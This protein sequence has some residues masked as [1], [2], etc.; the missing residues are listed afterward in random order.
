[1]SAVNTMTTPKLQMVDLQ[2][3]YQHIKHEIL[4]GFENVLNNSAYI[5]GQ[6]VNDLSENLSNYLNCKHVIPCGNGTD[7]LLAALMALDLQ[8]GD[9]IITVPFT[10]V[11]TVEV[12]SLLGL[13]PVFVDIHPETYN[14]DET[15]LEK[16]IS[17]K[18][19]VIIP[20]HLYGQCCNMEAICN[21]AKEN[22]LFVVEDNAQSIGADYTFSDG[23]KKKS[24]TI[25]DIGCTSFYPSKN[26]GA[27][28][29]AGAIFTNN[30]EIAVKL[31][32]IANHGQR[33]KYLSEFVGLNSRLDS[34]Q[35]VVLNTKL[36]YLDNYIE[37]RRK[38]ADFYDNAFKNIEN[39]VIPKRVNYSNHVFHQYTLHVGNQRDKIKEKLASAG[40]PSM[41]YYPY[42]LH[43]HPAYAYLN[44]KE[45]DFPIG[46]KMAKEVIS[47]PMHTELS[48]TDLEYISQT[49]CEIAN[50]L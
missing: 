23:S 33:A 18:T 14:M 7:A 24:G 47:L 25:G 2:T 48:V 5:N 36:K 45:G 32:N 16:V 22:N 26:L 4:E 29:D 41:I 8:P 20:V 31:K 37:A 13:K 3:Q 40:I 43:L 12:I 42:P 11:A 19:K 9:E 49:V 44:Y 6:P 10:F 46:E 38:A 28:G 39:L 17:K 27:Y 34:L 30:D 1:M 50:K 35:A 21:I 15:Q